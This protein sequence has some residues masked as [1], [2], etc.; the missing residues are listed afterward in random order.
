LPPNF[1]TRLYKWICG[2]R[3][4]TKLH[5]SEIPTSEGH[6]EQVTSVHSAGRDLSKSTRKEIKALLRGGYSHARFERVIQEFP[7]DLRSIVPDGL[8]YSA[9]QVLE[10]MRIAQRHML[11][12]ALQQLIGMPESSTKILRWPRDYWVTQQAPPGIDSWERSV[13]SILVD[14]K[15]FEALIDKATDN[16]L[17]TPSDPRNRKTLLRLALQISDHN[18]YHIGQLVLIRRLLRSWKR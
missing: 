14:R 2:R 18:S 3:R 17:V 6:S 15:R 12:Y 13:R 4:T 5:P 1:G 8:P 16:D 7:I 10:H 9:W 11:D